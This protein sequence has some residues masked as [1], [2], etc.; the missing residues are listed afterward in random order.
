MADPQLFSKEWIIERVKP[1][2]YFHRM[3]LAIDEIFERYQRIGA[4]INKDYEPLINE[5]WKKYLSACHALEQH[6]DYNQ[7]RDEDNLVLLTFE[8]RVLYDPAANDFAFI[9]VVDEDEITFIVSSNGMMQ[10]NETD[11]IYRVK[12]FGIADN[13]RNPY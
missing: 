6:R 1:R 2:D 13:H 3:S 11:L 9:F 12:V 8:P 7:R 5:I 10:A 4:F